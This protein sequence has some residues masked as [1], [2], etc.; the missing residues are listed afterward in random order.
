M[1][2]KD[3]AKGSGHLE[4]CQAGC[5]VGRPLCCALHQPWGHLPMDIALLTERMRKLSSL[6][7]PRTSDLGVT[8][9]TPAHVEK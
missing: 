1:M 8:W 7:K 4:I 3:K 9:G 6:G 2:A 5:P